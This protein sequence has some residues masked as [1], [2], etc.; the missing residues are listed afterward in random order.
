[1]TNLEACDQPSW[2]GTDEMRWRRLGKCETGLSIKLID[3]RAFGSRL[4]G[5]PLPIH[6]LP[7][8]NSLHEFKKE[9]RAEEECGGVKRGG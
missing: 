8:L 9:Y 2:V 6:I 1:M 5:T 4:E 7:W 3:A